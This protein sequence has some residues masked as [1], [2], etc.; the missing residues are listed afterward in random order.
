MTTYCDCIVWREVVAQSVTRAGSHTCWSK[1]QTRA[2][3]PR[4]SLIGYAAKFPH[5]ILM[6]YFRFLKYANWSR[7]QNPC[8]LIDPFKKI[9]DSDWLGAEVHLL[10]THFP[11]IPLWH[12][13]LTLLLFDLNN[14]KHAL[15]QEFP[16]NDKSKQVKVC[17]I[18]PPVI[19][20]YLRINPRTWNTHIS[21]AVEFYG[22][23]L[24]DKRNGE[25]ILVCNAFT[26]EGNTFGKY[27]W[28]NFFNGIF[29][30]YIT[31][32]WKAMKIVCGFMQKTA[33]L[34]GEKTRHE[35]ILESGSV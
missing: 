10:T 28:M 8:N 3:R 2:L 26:K 16:A 27:L 6:T 33:T 23:H 1:C 32:N 11:M 13:S 4:L 24:V 7:D 35:L 22:C 18:S 29:F 12:E 20:Q 31:I 17:V 25:W 14:S 15:S 34:L 30:V 21:M 9:L 19:S 5:S